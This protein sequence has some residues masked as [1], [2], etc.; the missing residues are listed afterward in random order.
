[1]LARGV[2]EGFYWCGAPRHV[3]DQICP[4]IRA[5]GCVTLTARH[6]ALCYTDLLSWHVV[7]CCV[8]LACGA[9]TVVSVLPKETT[10]YKQ[11]PCLHAA[12]SHICNYLVSTLQHCQASFDKQSSPRN[13]YPQHAV[14]YSDYHKFHHSVGPQCDSRA[15]DRTT[16]T[17]ATTTVSPPAIRHLPSAI[18]Y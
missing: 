9:A 7:F 1:M 6:R 13:D 16:G 10:L 18:Q 4:Q 15:S 8:S 11:P 17:C 5:C 3:I 12:L 2:V 14:T